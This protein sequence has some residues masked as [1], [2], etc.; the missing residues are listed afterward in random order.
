MLKKL[1]TEEKTY[2]DYFFHH[3]DMEAAEIILQAFLSCTGVIFF[4][5]VGKSGII[6]QKIAATL[7]STGTQAIYL[8]PT[9]ALHG[10]L[11]IVR[12]KDLFVFISK[13]GESDELLHLLP[14]IRNKGA[15]LIGF[16]S[17]NQ[18][19]LAKACD[20]FV[21]LPLER[22]LCPFDMVPTTSTEI[23]LIFGDVL[24]IALMRAKSFSLDDFAMNHPAG[25]LGRRMTLHVKDLM[26]TGHSVPLGRKEDK[27]IDVLVELSNKRCGCV[28]IV[29]ENLALQGIFTDGDLRRALQTKG[30]EILEEKMEVLMTA[31][32]KWIGASALAWDAMKLME[33]DQKRPVMVLPVLDNQKVTGI[34]KLHDLVQSGL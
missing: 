31:K 2:L 14:N 17:N 1:F 27:L 29:D 15:C 24:A 26:L 28:I 6:A 30:P 25:R 4:T 23:Q 5:G 32:P 12:E 9:D 18:S 10:D 13:S 8:T 7:I 11:G 33:A 34:I 21:T 3:L 19:R 20:L 22:E 16:V